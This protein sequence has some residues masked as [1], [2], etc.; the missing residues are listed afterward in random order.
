MFEFLRSV[1]EFLFWL[2]SRRTL[3]GA[4]NVPSSGGYLMIINHQSMV[5]IA[6]LFTLL[7]HP[8][9]SALVTTKY[10][11]NW[12]FHWLLTVTNIIWLRRGESDRAALKVAI[13]RMRD[14]VLVGIAPEG[15]R[16]TSGGLLAGL[17]G[18]AFL[19]VHAGVPVLPVALLHTA[20][21]FGELKR[22]RRPHMVM[23]V[24]P[25]FTVPPLTAG[26]RSAQLERITED[27]MLRLAAMLPAARRGVYAN[28]TRLAEFIDWAKANG[29]AEAEENR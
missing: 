7:P 23:K 12:F 18:A 1:F 20:T 16:S 3:L 21:A 17:P 8:R 22:L 19:A 5:D 15:T 27:M 13:D 28:H 29:L 24:G 25:P 10:K 9:L 2:L 4:K 14:G 6:L 26:N 11:E